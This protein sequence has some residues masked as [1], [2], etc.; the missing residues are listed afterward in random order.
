MVLNLS[1]FLN[2]TSEGTSK[3]IFNKLRSADLDVDCSGQAS[4][5]AVD[6]AGKQKKCNK[7][8][9]T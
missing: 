3:M 4:D 5:A 9:N 1:Y 7:V 8:S 6:M 2:K